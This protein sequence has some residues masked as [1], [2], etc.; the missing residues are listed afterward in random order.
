LASSDNSVHLPLLR[1]Q[2]HNGANQNAAKS[3]IISDS[4]RR[5]VQDFH[6]RPLLCCLSK[7]EGQQILSEIHAGVCRGHIG[8]RALATKILRQGFYWSAMINDVAKLVSTCQA[9]QKFSRKTKASAQPV[10]LIAP[11][12]HRYHWKVDSRTG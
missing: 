2:Q 7:D 1:A 11:S 9:C 6:L 10:Q 12:S 3:S 4:Q 8:A 5:F